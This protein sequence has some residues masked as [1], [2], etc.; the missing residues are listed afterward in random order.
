MDRD[1][2]S[3]VDKELL[4]LLEHVEQR[5]AALQVS[6]DR[7]VAVAKET[8]AILATRSRPLPRL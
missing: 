5:F 2:I 6:L 7:C 8:A 4:Q 3:E 1:E